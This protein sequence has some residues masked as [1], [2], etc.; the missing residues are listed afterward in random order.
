MKISKILEVG[1]TVYSS[2]NGKPMKVT[3]IYSDGFDTEDD[4]YSFDEHRD[5]FFLTKIGY[6]QS[7]EKERNNG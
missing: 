2:A 1:N 7:I 6:L 4:Y 3:K 5:L